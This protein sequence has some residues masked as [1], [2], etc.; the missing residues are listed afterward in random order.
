MPDVPMPRCVAVRA[1]QRLKVFNNSDANGAPG[2]VIAV[3]WA[4]FP[5]RHVEIGAATTFNLPLGS[6]LEPG[7]HFLHI[8]LYPGS[9]VEVFL[10]PKR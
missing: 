9:A 5:V 7:D 8:S 3:T 2:S 1:D 4:S 6:Y 10:A